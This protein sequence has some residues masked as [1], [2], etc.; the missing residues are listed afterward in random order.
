MYVLIQR[1]VYN[2]TINCIEYRI[3]KQDLLDRLSAWDGFLKRKVYLIACGGTA[4][5]ILGIK[6]LTKDIDLMVP[7]IDEY[8]YIIKTLQQIGYKSVS[9]WGWS[10]GDQFIF[11]IFRGNAVHT[12]NLLESP[13]EARK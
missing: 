11:D 8:E 10:R 1:I 7:N 12:T 6:A 5:T 9:G 13:S 4:M 2:N 3:D